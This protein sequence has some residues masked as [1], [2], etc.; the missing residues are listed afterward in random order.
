[1][2]EVTLLKM[3][4]ESTAST[5]LVA[6]MKQM[7][8]SMNTITNQIKTSNEALGLQIKNSKEELKIEIAT[9]SNKFEKEIEE[10]KEDS[11]I[12]KEE[13]KNVKIGNDENKERLKRMED[14]LGKIEKEKDKLEKQKRKR[15]VI[16][17][18]SVAEKP[19]IQPAGSSY[20]DKLK[21]STITE[22][23]VAEI[24]PVYKSTWAKKM[25][26]ISLEQQLIAA[27]EAAQR[28]EVENNGGESEF[29]RKERTNRGKKL[30]L[31]DSLDL[32]SPV[33]WPWDESEKDW[34]GLVDKVARNKMK[35]QK[36]QEKKLKKLDKAIKIGKSSIGIGP[37]K[38][39]SFNYFN[40]ITADYDEAK[41][42][43]AVEF[44]QEYLKFDSE[45]LSDLNITDT[46]TSNKKDDILYIVLDSPTKVRDIRRRVADC[47][48]PDV[49]TRDY[50]PPMFFERYV[51]L[52]RHAFLMREQNPH[53]KTQIRFSNDDITLYTKI[54]GTEEPFVEMDMTELR[55]KLPDIDYRVK[56]NMRSEKPPMRKKVSPERRNIALKS[57]GGNPVQKSNSPGPSQKKP[58]VNPVSGQQDDG[59]MDTEC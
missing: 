50:I 53:L 40:N 31:G 34:D 18:D 43:A 28:L 24:E 27:T 15:D 35:K 13:V 33:D 29:K 42:M 30:K 6:F 14:R 36:D 55:T 48:N 41:K 5:D 11:K 8:M 38:E 57:L 4:D 32:H 1:M 9:L 45:D 51:A 22:P 54:K 46:K 47:R 16:E 20:S 7:Q 59:C 17:K 39:Q 37:I 44:L 52:G 58:R 19:A 23:I 12:L 25:S 3:D 21:I 10:V 56:W 2:I 49:K 26:Q